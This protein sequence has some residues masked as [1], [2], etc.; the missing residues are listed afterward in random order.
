MN[1]TIKQVKYQ[2]MNLMEKLLHFIFRQFILEL[3]F[4]KF[5][6]KFFFC[7]AHWCPPCRNFT[8]KLAKIFKE[9]NNEVKNKLDI[10]FVSWDKDQ[11]GFNEYFNEMPWKAL[12][13]SGMFYLF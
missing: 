12:P 10:V 11:E 6:K 7:R 8:P 4:K 2:Q 9:I 5:L 13:F 3:I 1:L